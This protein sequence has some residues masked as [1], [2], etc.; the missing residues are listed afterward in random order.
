MNDG[1]HKWL[2]EQS[3]VDPNQS[4]SEPRQ[5]WNISLNSHYEIAVVGRR[6]RIIL[7]S[8]ST[9]VQLS[10]IRIKVE[11]GNK[12]WRNPKHLWRKARSEDVLV[13]GKLISKPAASKS[14][15]HTKKEKKRKH[16]F[17][18]P[19]LPP[20]L[21]PSTYLSGVSDALHLPLSSVL[22]PGSLTPSFSS[23]QYT[24]LFSASCHTASLKAPPTLSSLLSLYSIW[25]LA[26]SWLQ[27]LT[28]KDIAASSPL[29]AGIW[30]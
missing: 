19:S 17:H 13:A 16:H 1:L 10:E 18:P 6:H 8:P 4:I 3:S 28:I 20:C 15:F 11:A 22:H 2:P 27:W 25:S 26:M 30:L 14:C 24:R 23:P 9:L 21:P 29:P 5:A 12:S 7:R